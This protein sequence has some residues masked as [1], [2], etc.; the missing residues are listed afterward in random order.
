M[1]QSQF[2]QNLAPNQRNNHSFEQCVYR[3]E[4]VFQMSDTCMAHEPLVFSF[5]VNKNTTERKKSH[6]TYM[7]NLMIVFHVMKKKDTNGTMKIMPSL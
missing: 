6:L 4:L 2:Q 3:F 7:E 5:F 1:N